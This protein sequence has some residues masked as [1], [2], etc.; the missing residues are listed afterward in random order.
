VLGDPGKFQSVGQRARQT[1]VER[2]DLK[3]RCLP[4]LMKLMTLTAG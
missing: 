4:E 1:V 2:Y 3:T